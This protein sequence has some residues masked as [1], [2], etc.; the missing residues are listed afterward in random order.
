MVLLSERI[1]R[2]KDSHE[3]HIDKRNQVLSTNQ[4]MCSMGLRIE[5]ET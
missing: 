3:K 1:R 2:G 4:V 5:D